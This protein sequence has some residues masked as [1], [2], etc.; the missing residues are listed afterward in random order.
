MAEP[1]RTFTFLQHLPWH[2]RLWLRMGGRPRTE[3]EAIAAIR[4]HHAALGLPALGSDEE[5]I[6]SCNGIAEA[7]RH[8]E[9]SLPTTKQAAEACRV[10]AT[11]E[12]ADRG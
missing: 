3:R 1:K 5:V 11:L 7:M 9:E 4:D 6:D 2:R 8:I 10:F 12:E